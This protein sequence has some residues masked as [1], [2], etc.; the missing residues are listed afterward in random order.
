M[1]SFSWNF[2]TCRLFLGCRLFC[3]CRFLPKPGLSP[4]LNRRVVDLSSTFCCAEDTE[5]R[6]LYV[7]TAVQSL[8]DVRIN[9]SHACVLAHICKCTSFSCDMHHGNRSTW[10]RCIISPSQT[11]SLH[12]THSGKLMKQWEFYF[13]SWIHLESHKFHAAPILN[14]WAL[15]ARLQIGLRWDHFVTRAI[16]SAKGHV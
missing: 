15:S 1:E 10:P 5:G 7:S 8:F 6:L 16:Y 4:H 13:A 12:P 9:I 14:R 3:C 11:V 2:W